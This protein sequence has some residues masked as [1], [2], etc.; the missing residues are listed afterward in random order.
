MSGSLGQASHPTMSVMETMVSLN[1]QIL[2]LSL[3]IIYVKIK[4]IILSRHLRYKTH[5][6]KF[7]KNDFLKAVN[8]ED[9]NISRNFA[10]R[11]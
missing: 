2:Q 9:I 7:F 4:R 6:F 3:E 1:K 8:G 5:G 11:I 10:Y